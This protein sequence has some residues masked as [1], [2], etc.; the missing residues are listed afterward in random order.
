MRVWLGTFDTAEEAARAYDRAAIRIRGR[1][2]KLNFSSSVH[3]FEEFQEPEKKKRRN[4]NMPSRKGTVEGC[5]LPRRSS[6]NLAPEMP[7]SQFHHAADFAIPSDNDMIKGVTCLKYM[8]DGECPSTGHFGSFDL[9][10]LISNPASTDKELS[11]ALQSGNI[12]YFENALQRTSDDSQQ[13][14]NFEE[15]V[16]VFDT[17]HVDGEVTSTK[18]KHSKIFCFPG[19]LGNPLPVDFCQTQSQAHQQQV[20]QNIPVDDPHVGEVCR[21]EPWCE[22]FFTLDDLLDKAFCDAEATMQEWI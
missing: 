10:R 8:Q 9:Q 16:K 12:K 13:P 22:D 5:G 18:M 17:R 3:T 21:A 4:A 19:E 1:K 11:S 14:I 20:S 2:A 15:D 6:S 7:S